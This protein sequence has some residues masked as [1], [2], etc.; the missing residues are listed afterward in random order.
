MALEIFLRLDGVTGGTSNY[1]YRGWADV[2]SW[3]WGLTRTRSADGGARETVNMNRI[4]IVKPVGI[5]TPAMM[6]LFAER[7]VIKTAEL[8]VVPVVG[9]RETQQKYIEMM[10]EGVLI[11]SIETGGCTDDSAFTET[12]ALRFGK[13]NYNY[14]H[15][16]GAVHG[17]AEATDQGY[18]FAWDIAAKAAE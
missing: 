13:L 8:C 18:A 16:T 9:K 7:T 6:K 14:Y 3:A 15:H 11:Q 1:S 12:I 10:L 17:G 4:S 5:E 2:Q